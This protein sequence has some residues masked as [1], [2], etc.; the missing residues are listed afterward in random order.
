MTNFQ[1]YHGDIEVHSTQFSSP[2]LKFH[3][4]T[5]LFRLTR[6][7]QSWIRKDTIPQQNVCQMKV[8]LITYTLKFCATSFS[9]QSFHLILT[10][11]TTNLLQSTLIILWESYYCIIVFSWRSCF[12]I[13]LSGEVLFPNQLLE[14]CSQGRSQ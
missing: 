4:N 13:V 1:L 2:L 3:E 9:T 6:C 5:H 8:L 11:K 14:S 10:E 7:L 12:P